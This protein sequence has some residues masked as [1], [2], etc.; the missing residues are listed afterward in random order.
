MIQARK[1][2]ELAC[3]DAKY[4]LFFS[5]KGLHSPHYS[6]RMLE[7]QPSIIS[8]K[9]MKHTLFLVRLD[10]IIEARCLD[11][12]TYDVEHIKENLDYLESIAITKK[13]LVLNCAAPFTSISPEA[14]SYIAGGPHHHIIK[15]EAYVIHSLAQKL[16]AQFFIKVNKPIVEA[17]Y[18]NS[19]VVAEQWLL[20]RV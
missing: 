20:K 4:H 14:R 11:N 13:L 16:L 3:I 12:F 5:S 18:F 19:K 17:N 6:E 7:L 10:G 1:R 15:A 9:D 2:S 8:R